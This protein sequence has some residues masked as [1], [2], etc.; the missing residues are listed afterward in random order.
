MS[1]KPVTGGTRAFPHKAAASKTS[2]LDRIIADGGQLEIGDLIADLLKR[3]LVSPDRHAALNRLSILTNRH[4][5][6]EGS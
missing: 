5:P 4:G 3:F 2:T 6:R 1:L